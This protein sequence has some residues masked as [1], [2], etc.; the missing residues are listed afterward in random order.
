MM[1]ELLIV[2]HCIHRLNYSSL[3]HLWQQ[4]PYVLKCLFLLLFCSVGDLHVN[5]MQLPELNGNT[6]KVHPSDENVFFN[7][8][9]GFVERSMVRDRDKDRD[10]LELCVFGRDG[11]ECYSGAHA[12]NFVKAEHHL[13]ESYHFKEID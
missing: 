13:F 1:F 2:Q 8:T 12:L 3:R 10:I 4:A 9:Y 11:F 6:V 5:C 7:E